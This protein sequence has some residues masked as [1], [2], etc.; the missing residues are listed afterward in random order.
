VLLIDGSVVDVWADSLT[1]TSG[2]DD[3]RDYAFGR[4]TDIDPSMQGD[5][6]ITART[7]SNP[8]RVEVLVVRFPRASVR[9]IL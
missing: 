1:G 2:P 3:D 5:F 6:E 4:L 8:K 7:P 9:E